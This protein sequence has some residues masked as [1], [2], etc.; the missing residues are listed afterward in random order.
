MSFSRIFWFALLAT[1]GAL[2][3]AAP[4]PE[5]PNIVFILADDP[6]DVDVSAFAARRSG[7]KPGAM[8]FETPNLDRFTRE[9]TALLN[10]ADDPAKEARSRPFVD[11][12]KQILGEAFAIRRAASDPWME[13]LRQINR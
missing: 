3:A 6:G 13:V 12:C 5:R 2:Q 4:P 1:A 10:P 9:G 7:E 8:Y 11:L